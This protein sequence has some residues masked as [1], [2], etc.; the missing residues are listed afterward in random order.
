MQ[1]NQISN[2]LKEKD[3]LQTVELNELKNQLIRMT[4]SMQEYSDMKVSYKK[5]MNQMDQ[6]TVERGE[7]AQH[8]TM[9]KERINGIKE[10]Y[11]AE[12]Q[13]TRNEHWTVTD[14]NS[15]LKIEIE[16]L[17]REIDS[18]KANTETI[19]KKLKQHAL[20]IRAEYINA[21][22]TTDSRRVSM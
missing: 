16:K 15:S 20:Q 5:M 19:E 8:I 21:N 6:I 7:H 11:E 22:K 13:K 18:I 17:K 2:K 14:E 9:M 10:K 3:E 4:N 1:A 12:L